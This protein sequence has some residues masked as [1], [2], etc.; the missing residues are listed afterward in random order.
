MPDTKLIK[1]ETDYLV[2]GC[3]AMSIAFVDE[4]LHSGSQAEIILVDKHAKPG[5]HWNDAYQFVT[6]HQ[7]AAY[8]G[9]NSKQLGEGGEDL[10]SKSQILAYYELVMKDFLATNRVKFFSLCEYLGDNRFKSVVDHDVE[11]EVTVRKKT[12]D[13]TYMNVEVPSI[14]KPKFNVDS[15]VTLVPVNGIADIRSPWEKYIVLGAGKT[16]IDAVLFLL[17]QNVDPD[18]I[19]WIMPNDAWLFNRDTLQ[20]SVLDQTTY[21]MMNIVIRYELPNS[22]L[23]FQQDNCQKI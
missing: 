22:E 3:G 5:G 7:P 17:S 15:D 13:G 12:V 8:Y 21:G 18:N 20:P 6:L 19:T 9:V 2:V 10:V 4:I 11:Y 16:G 14:T 1:L 23:P